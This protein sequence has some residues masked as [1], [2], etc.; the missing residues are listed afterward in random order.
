[1]DKQLTEK[2]QAWLSEEHSSE[3]KIREGAELLLSLN[4]NRILYANICNKPSR[5]QWKDKL[6]YELRKHLNIRLD[7]FTRDEVIRLDVRVS[8]EVDAILGD[9]WEKTDPDGS[10][11]IQLKGKRQDHDALPDSIKQLFQSNH[12]R[13]MKIRALHATLRTME[14][15]PSCDRYEYLKQLDELDTEY[16][17]NMEQYDAYVIEDSGDGGSAP[18]ETTKAGDHQVVTVNR[19]WISRNKPKLAKLKEAADADE[20]DMV[21]RQAYDDF[22]GVFTGK[23]IEVLR[24]GGEFQD[25]LKSELE[26]LGIVFPSADIHVEDEENPEGA[27]ADDCREADGSAE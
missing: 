4:R 25:K 13:Y 22:A 8:K 11:M 27:E 5:P 7:G 15:A 12:E 18:S 10:V 3:D 2:I 24:N 26:S 17:R 14:N 9:G 23:V 16:R 6:E 21:A 19:T 1:M 20:N